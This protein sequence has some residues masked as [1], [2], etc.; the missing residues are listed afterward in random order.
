MLSTELLIKV[1]AASD[2][3][4]DALRLPETNRRLRDVW[5]EHSTQIIEPALRMSIPA[6]ERALDLAVIETW[7]QCSMD[8]EP[9]LQ[10]CLPSLLRNAVLCASACLAYSTVRGDDPSLPTSYYFLRRVGLGYEY[11]Q[12]RDEL[13]AELLAMSRAALLLPSHTG[14]WLLLDASLAEQQRQGVEDE[15][16]DEIRDAYNETET[17]WDYAIYCIS[18]GAIGDIDLGTNNL[19]T[20]IQGY[21]I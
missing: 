18:N 13:Y 12:F 21:D 4:L 19:P 10:R 20:T 15:D 16:Y 6:Y 1:F 11:P 7:L 2:T 8:N 14:R 17:K 3:I 5:L 9:S